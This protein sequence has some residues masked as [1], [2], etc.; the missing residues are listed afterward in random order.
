M[1][2]RLIQTQAQKLQQLQ[3]LTAQQMLQVKLLEMPL[4]EL[5]ESVNAEL[6]DNPALESE[7]PDDMLNESYD[8]DTP[9]DNDSAEN[10][11]DGDDANDEDAYEAQ[12]EQEE[13]KDE[14]D[15]ALE[16]IGQD[17]QMPDY[18]TDSYSNQDSA[19]YEE[20]VYGDTTS[21]YDKLKEQM[22]MQV[23][24]DKEKQVMEYLI[25]S[26][27]DDGLLR[28][29]LD[30]ISD[31]LA[32]YHNLDVDEKDVEHVL[33]ILQTFD[34]AGVGAR[35][36]QEC[37]L[38]Q[39]KR[40][41]RGVLRK[42]LEEIFTDYFEEFTKKHWDKIKTG[43]ELNDT[44]LETVQEEIR[45]LN[46]KPGA[47]MGETEG[48]NMQQITPDFIVDTNDDG[49]ITFTLNRGNIPQLTVSPSFTD[50]IDT[51]KKNKANMSRSDK[52]ALLYA[53]EKVDK[54]Q[55]FI[56]AIKQRRH[57]LIVT[58]KAIIDI[59]RQFFLDGDEADLKPMILKDV[60]DRTGLDIST[61]S[62]VSNVKY[63][64]TKWGTFP[65]K[66]FFTDGYTTESGEE[67]STRK[68]KIALQ[69]LIDHEDKKKPLSDDAIAKVMKEKGFPIARRTVAKYREQLGIPVARLRK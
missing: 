47:S 67:M 55:G 44:Q 12:S 65:L 68:I 63:A 28:K 38:L 34:P 56:E 33:H 11:N 4:T 36:L 22:D 48:R 7:N 21:F 69:E 60:A 43:L 51:Y 64:Q 49:T 27:D 1:A 57:T 66:F 50:M 3:R 54:A 62:R 59:Q 6:D 18:N 45:K 35:S 16:S 13:R 25:G 52:E 41:P 2:Q 26:L 17:D 30:S 9:M 29:D 23:L 5:E 39:V 37:L 14:L 61:I 58:M 31:E 8:G 32:I 20:M 40:M 42:T 19:D 15:Q 24:T 46:P 10:S 53:K